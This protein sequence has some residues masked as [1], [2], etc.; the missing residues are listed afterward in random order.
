[1]GYAYHPFADPSN[2]KLTNTLLPGIGTGL[3]IVSFYDFV[4]RLEYSVNRWAQGGFYM[5]IGA[6]V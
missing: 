3:E 5:Y 1:M 4:L 6:D 2:L